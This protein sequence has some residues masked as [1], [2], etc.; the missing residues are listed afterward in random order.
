[1]GPIGKWPEGTPALKLAC[2]R[3]WT[4]LLYFIVLTH[5]FNMDPRFRALRAEITATGQLEGGAPAPEMV[6]VETETHGTWHQMRLELPLEAGGE[7]DGSGTKLQVAVIRTPAD[8][9]HLRPPQKGR[10]S[11]TW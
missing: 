9:F 1:M 6:T 3:I 10:K 11:N 4:G 5:P 2:H 7:L 8:V